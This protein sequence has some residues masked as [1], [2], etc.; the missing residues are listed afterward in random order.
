[1]QQTAYT[2][3]AMIADNSTN[4]RCA[5][6]VVFGR[7]DRLYPEDHNHGFRS[8]TEYIHMVKPDIVVMNAGAHM[9][10]LAHM[11]TVFDELLKQVV[12]MM[13]NTKVPRLVWKTISP[14]HYLC[15]RA[16]EPIQNFT[17]FYQDALAANFTAAFNDSFHYQS[18]PAYDALSQKWQPRIGYKMLSVEPLY[19]RA[20]AHVTVRSDCLHLCTPGPLD[21]FSVLLLNMLYNGEV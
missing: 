12:V 10:D 9:N 4:G 18:F 13:N 5:Q 17:N 16:V 21:L 1:M 11:N 6:R 7:S 14:G 19:L 20:D 8:F 2:L 15:S 3:H